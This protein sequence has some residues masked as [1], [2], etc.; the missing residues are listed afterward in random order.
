MDIKQTIAVIS[1]GILSTVATY[2]LLK[3]NDPNMNKEIKK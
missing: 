3:A 1:T 2:Y